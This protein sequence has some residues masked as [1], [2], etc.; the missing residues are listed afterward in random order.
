MSNVKFV[1]STL[2]HIPVQTAASAGVAGIQL[3]MEQMVT[4]L[5]CCSRLSLYDC[6]PPHFYTFMRHAQNMNLHKKISCIHSSCNTTNSASSQC[7]K[8][9]KHDMGRQQSATLCVWYSCMKTTHVPRHLMLP[10]NPHLT[11][12][13][14]C[15]KTFHC[16][17]VLACLPVPILLTT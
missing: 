17:V 16:K 11:V 9:L 5:H 4:L 7:I 8:S 1:L 12:L 10:Q 3:L 13:C 14:T 2:R 6:C 15:E